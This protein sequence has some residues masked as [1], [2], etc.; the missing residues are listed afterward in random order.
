MPGLPSFISRSGFGY[1]SPFGAHQLDHAPAVCRD[2]GVDQVFAVQ[3]E[4]G[5]GARLVG[6]HEA[7]IADHVRGQD[8]GEP[9]FQA[10]SPWAGRLHV[11]GCEIYAPQK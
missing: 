3:F 11:E 9:A 1:N 5:Q 7:A 4:R 10:R 8:R 6:L 2:L